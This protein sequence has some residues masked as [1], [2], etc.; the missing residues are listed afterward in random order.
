MTRIGIATLTLAMVAGVVSEATAQP[1]KPNILVIMGDDIRVPGIY[2]LRADPFE[3]GPES[4][5]YAK[6][7][8]ERVFF[9]VPAQAA[10][11]QWLQ[12]FKEFPIRQKPTSFNLDEV[13]QKL[14]PKG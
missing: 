9:L 5:E 2:N 13:M 3:R 12:T 4:F 11:A 6:W 7:K 10:V 1:K 8:A 14:A